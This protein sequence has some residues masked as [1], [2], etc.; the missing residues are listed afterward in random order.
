MFLLHSNTRLNIIRFL[1]NNSYITLVHEIK[2]GSHYNLQVKV[3]C[4]NIFTVLGIT[5]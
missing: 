3:K 4:L 2:Y 5:Y 1:R